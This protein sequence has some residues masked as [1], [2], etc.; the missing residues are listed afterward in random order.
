MTTDSLVILYL[1]N[2]QLYLAP[3]L[4]KFKVSMS[5]SLLGC[6]TTSNNKPTLAPSM[7]IPCWVRSLCIN[8]IQGAC[9]IAHLVRNSDWFWPSITLYPSS[10]I[11]SHSQHQV[12][13]GSSPPVES[14]LRP[15]SPPP[16]THIRHMIRR[17]RT[18]LHNE[19]PRIRSP[20]EPTP[21]TYQFIHPQTVGFY[22]FHTILVSFSSY[23]SYYDERGARIGEGDGY[24]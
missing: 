2:G 6:N 3:T 23:F 14:F 11:P 18:I 24:R 8:P 15:T 9:I 4:V 7:R 22:M 19:F 12:L 20:S 21:P 1:T 5:Y 17:R 16:T 13:S 10:L